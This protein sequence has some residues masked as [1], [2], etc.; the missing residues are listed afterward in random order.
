M[1]LRRLLVLPAFALLFVGTPVLATESTDPPPVTTTDVPVAP[2]QTVDAGWQSKATPVDA[3]LV[4]VTW[5]GDAKTTFTVEVRDS[6]GLWSA[7]TAL[8]SGNET[9]PGTKDAERAATV[10]THG[11]EPVWVG[12][13]A[14]AVRVKVT[15]G[16]ATDVSVAAVD[17]QP[18]GVPAGS[19]GALG[20]IAPQ[21]GG[22]ERYLFAG[23]LVAV[24]LLLIAVAMGWSPWRRRRRTLLLAA[25]GLLVLSACVPPAP[26][27]PPGNGDVMPAMTTRAQWGA[28][29][30]ACSAVDYAP[31]LKFAVVHHT[32]NSNSYGPGDSPA[33]VRAIQSYELDALGYCDIAYNF[34]VDRFG[35]I[36]E[37]RAGGVDKPVI[38]GH[39]GGF[40]TAS[41]GVAIIG[42]YTRI[43]APAAQWN[44][45][46]HLLR[47]RLSVARINPAAG[48]STTVL[49]SPCN[50]Q[51]WPV[52]TNITLPSA[53]VGH[54]DVDQT[55]CPGNTFY[56]QLPALRDQVQSGIVIPPLAPAVEVSFG[57]AVSPTPGKMQVLGRTPAGTVTTASF[58]GSAWQPW[59]DIGG[60]S[61]SKIVAA[62][63]APGQIVAATRGTDNAYW[64]ATYDGTT[65]SA[66]TSR[67]GSWTSDPALVADSSG[68]L[69]LV[70]RAADKSASWSSFS[71]GAWTAW[72]SLGGTWTSDP[73]LVADGA[74]HVF[75]FLRGTDLSF[76][77][78]TFSAGAWSG[79]TF[80]GGSLASDPSAAVDGS[81]RVHLFGRGT[82]DFLWTRL[83]DGAWGG[84][85]ALGERLTSDPESATDTEGSVHVAARVGD[86][87]IRVRQFRASWGGW[88]TLGYGATSDPALAS[89]GAGGIFLL[90]QVGGD[91]AMAIKYQAG[92]W[93]PWWSLGSQQLKSVR[94]APAG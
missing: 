41:T 48:F 74:G 67:G 34:L 22:P 30:F 51:Q 35:Q 84:W 15:D 65:W 49:S 46:V 37:G 40:N 56:P 61:T 43:N 81:G 78:A 93:G 28:R 27:S 59:Q 16:S 29:P 21:L 11:S 85:S 26:P 44:S 69:V 8:D 66:W 19:A 7:A 23:A 77:T 75:L 10:P 63:P 47:W 3:T 89:D 20:T 70:G 86:T 6:E 24:A 72:T 68:K 76:I 94:G 54:R 32:V 18:N 71:A 39:A 25:L 73:E 5:K 50:C 80:L 9:D 55:A 1:R 12:T 82:D 91:T 4:G 83:Y 79:W 52:G 45:L 36:F 92:A 58:D 14:Q 31:R 90:T 42:D 64:T 88:T 87:L 53:I 13:D 60:T 2:A 33:I 17:S 62:S 38:G 57:A